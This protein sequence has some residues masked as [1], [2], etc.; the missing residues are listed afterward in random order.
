MTGESIDAAGGHE[1]VI[2]SLYVSSEGDFMEHRVSGEVH[3]DA[4]THVCLAGSPQLAVRGCK[5][6][7]PQGRPRPREGVQQAPV[8]LP[9]TASRINSESSTLCQ[10]TWLTE[11]TSD[12]WSALLKLAKLFRFRWSLTLAF[13]MP[14]TT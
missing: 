11:V 7:M 5:L 12:G 4:F 14:L 8:R 13:T 9:Y 1:H 10:S 3:T 6:A 2:S